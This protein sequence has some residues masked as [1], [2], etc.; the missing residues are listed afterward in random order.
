MR[1][2]YSSDETR[3]NYLLLLAEGILFTVG[4]VFFDPNTVL[5]LL[6]ERLTGS[7]FLVGVLS[8]VQLLAKGV[9]PLLAGNWISSLHYKKRFLVT[10]I[11]IGR[12]PLWILGGA[13][14]VP[15]LAG[16]SMPAAFWAALI[17]AVQMLFWFGD[18]AGDPA[19]MD[20]VGKSVPAGG[21]GRFFSIRQV[22][23]GLLSVAAGPA[24][25]AILRLGSVPFPAGY[26]IVVAIGAAVYTANVATF[27]GVV[28]R[29]SPTRERHSVVELVRRLPHYLRANRVFAG[30]LGVTVLVNGARIALPFFIIFGRQALGITE[31][32]L[33]VLLPLQMA[34][35]IVGALLWGHVGDRHGHHWGVRGVATAFTLPSLIAFVLAVTTPS[36]TVIFSLLF[37][38]LGFALEGWP[39][40]IN[41]MLDT[42]SEAER[43]R[44]AGIMSVGFVPAALAP[45][46]GGPVIGA[47][48][49]PTLFGIATALGIAALA[50]SATLPEPR[51]S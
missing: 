8:A 27:F 9:V 13:L 23:G 7:I 38:V 20:L 12:L 41:Y 31:A 32:A 47:F 24:V 18:S 22:V 16:R 25:A 46:L 11:A 26:G 2:S 34:G 39:P 29:P 6:M 10:V 28:E 1:S 17:L 5:P 15:T 4:L 36:T 49:Y 44:Y 33:A 19:W 43:P 37:F 40:F 51:G 48:G 45:L 3:R 30:M 21:R 50:L 35:R 14:I 42:V